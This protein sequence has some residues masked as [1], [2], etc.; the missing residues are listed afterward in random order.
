MLAATETM[1]LAGLFDVRDKVVL[2]TGGSR[3]IGRA[4]AEGL[5]RAGARVYIGGR[6][7]QRC[8]Q[9]A[10]EL[11]AFGTCLPLPGELNSVETAQ[12]LA[13]SL[14]ERESRLDVLINNA[15]TLWA[16]PI[17]DYPETG[18]DKVFDI[19]VKSVFFLIQSLLPLLR[20]AASAESPARIINV[21]SI[22]GFALAPHET[23]A[24]SASKAAVHHL[25]KVLADRLTRE[26]ITVNAIAP[27]IYPSKM[28]EGTVARDGEDSVLARVPMG[29][30]GKPT[31]LAGAAV[32]LSAPCSSYITGTV[33]PIDGGVGTLH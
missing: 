25:T 23:Y 9:S 2:I 21:G 28:V 15:G 16:A 29:R 32:F 19:N 4:M 13:A 30:L 1:N 14:A 33:L 3:G 24:Y 26:N 17:D 11:S 5:V 22:Q 7:V 12:T 20:N 31:D 8:E 27:G 18:W 6:D 10:A